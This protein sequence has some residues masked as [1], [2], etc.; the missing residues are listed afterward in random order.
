[1][2]ESMLIN[3]TVVLAGKFNSIKHV[4]QILRAKSCRMEFFGA[5]TVTGFVINFKGDDLIIPVQ[6]VPRKAVWKIQRNEQGDPTGVLEYL[7]YTKEHNDLMIAEKARRRR[8]YLIS[9]VIP[10]EKPVK[11]EEPLPLDNG[12]KFRGW[13]VMDGEKHYIVPESSEIKNDSIFCI[14]VQSNFEITGNLTVLSEISESLREKHT[15]LIKAQEA[16]NSKKE[17]RRRVS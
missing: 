5:N 4:W 3:N 6:D 8:R 12:T 17:K 2:E 7:T 13:V 16:S 9:Q 15:R 11:L 14:E 1:M 10:N